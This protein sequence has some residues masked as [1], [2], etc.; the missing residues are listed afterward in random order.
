[1]AEE[2]KKG[3]AGKEDSSAK[4]MESANAAAATS[5][6]QEVGQLWFVHWFQGTKCQMVSFFI[7]SPLP[8]LN[9]A[10]SHSYHLEYGIE[11]ILVSGYIVIGYT[12]FSGYT[13][14]WLGP[15]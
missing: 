5:E 8:S 13:V 6:Q 7:Q 10:Y 3:E 12:V 14:F 9:L 4:G 15:K 11:S 2:T 1:M